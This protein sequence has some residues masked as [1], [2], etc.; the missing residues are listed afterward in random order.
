MWTG[1]WIDYIQWLCANATCLYISAH[2]LSARFVGS[3]QKLHLRTWKRKSKS[4]SRLS[5]GDKRHLLVTLQDRAAVV[6]TRD[7]EISVLDL[8]KIKQLNWEWSH[9]RVTVRLSQ[10]QSIQ[11]AI[12]PTSSTTEVT[13]SLIT[14]T[15]FTCLACGSNCIFR[16]VKNQPKITR[17]FS[18]NLTQQEK[19]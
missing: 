2:F 5:A 9:T 13:F 6:N 3:L 15:N 18:T 12:T 14:V 7:S 1:L 11:P 16:F 4:K 17:V 19:S 10:I 8:S